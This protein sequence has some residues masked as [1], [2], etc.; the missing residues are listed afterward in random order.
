MENTRKRLLFIPLLLVIIMGCL[1]I[2][3]GKADAATLECEYMRDSDQSVTVGGMYFWKEIKGSTA[4]IM[5]SAKGMKVDG[6]AIYQLPDRSAYNHSFATDGKKVYMAIST[7]S[8]T[9]DK[10]LLQF[11]PETLK[12]KQIA[13]GDGISLMTVYG[14]SA[15]VSYWNGKQT[16]INI[17][18]PTGELKKTIQNVGRQYTAKNSRYVPFINEKGNLVMYNMKT[19]KTS[20]IAYA[21]SFKPFNDSLNLTPTK[22]YISK[23]LSTGKHGVYERSYTDSTLKKLTTIP[24]GTHVEKITSKY[25]FYS[26]DNPVNL[27]KP[28]CKRKTIA[29]GKILTYATPDL[30]RIDA[31][32]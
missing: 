20:V 18:S 5:Y 12:V 10:V 24:A 9:G 14:S 16:N 28:E 19:G 21:S 6:K 1:F 29:T 17:Y 26:K 15:A 32:F 22:M 4:N 30:Y 27:M 13:K 11:N 25:V 8:R 2:A 7:N 23:T 3:A 31:G